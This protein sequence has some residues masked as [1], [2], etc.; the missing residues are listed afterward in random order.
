[1]LRER[2]SKAIIGKTVVEARQIAGL[3]IVRVLRDN[4][5]TV[6]DGDSSNIPHRV[7][8]EVVDGV[9]KRIIYWG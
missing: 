8:V 4:T 5:G 3:F 7:N 2:F 9:I 6:S 1:M